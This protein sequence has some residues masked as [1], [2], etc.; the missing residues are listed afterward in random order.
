MLQ[1]M[2]D[3][4]YQEGDLIVT[5]DDEGDVTLKDSLNLMN[6]EAFD[7]ERITTERLDMAA[8]AKM[9]HRFDNFNE[10]EK[11]GGDD[12][13]LAPGDSHRHTRQHRNGERDLFQRASNSGRMVR[14]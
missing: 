10:Q 3:K 7:I 14:R 8:S 12:Y 9:F 1:F 6:D 2:K 11:H 5:K 13:H 4:Y